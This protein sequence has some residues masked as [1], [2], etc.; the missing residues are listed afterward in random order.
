GEACENMRIFKKNEITNGG[1]LLDV[2]TNK[3]NES[4]IFEENDTLEFYIRANHECY[5]RIINYFA[6]GTK[7]LLVDNLYIGSDKVNKVIKLPK[8]FYCAPPFGTEVLQANAQTEPF[9]PLITEEKCDYRFIKGDL[10]NILQ[11]T[12][13]FKPIKNEDLRAE[14]RIIVTTMKE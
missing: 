8:M 11:N 7:V 14:K 3:G 5:V 1:M 9:N 10:N 2:W 4:P 13:G 12:R 6:D